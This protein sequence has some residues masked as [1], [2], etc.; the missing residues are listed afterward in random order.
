M[1][2]SI[3]FVWVHKMAADVPRVA[4]FVLKKSWDL[5]VCACMHSRITFVNCG[6]PCNSVLLLFMMTPA[7]WTVFIDH[8]CFFYEYAR[9]AWMCY[10]RTCVFCVCMCM[11]VCVPIIPMHVWVSMCVCVHARLLHV[12]V[13]ICIIYLWWRYYLYVSVLYICLYKRVSY[14]FMYRLEHLVCAKM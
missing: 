5:F 7:F 2:C 14:M 6:M 12:W 8:E 10:C 13:S 1:F 3:Q 11:C 4:L 9:C